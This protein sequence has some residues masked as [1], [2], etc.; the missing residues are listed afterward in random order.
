MVL[1]YEFRVVDGGRQGEANVGS[2]SV[3][4]LHADGSVPGSDLNLADDV[5][6][7][8]EEVGYGV[9]VESWIKATAPIGQRTTEGVGEDFASW[10]EGFPGAEVPGYVAARSRGEVS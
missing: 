7:S 10:T 9:A 6:F 4:F 2:Q 8:A 3:D 5:G 1:L